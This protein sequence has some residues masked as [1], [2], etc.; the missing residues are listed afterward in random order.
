[1]NELP[2]ELVNRAINRWPDFV[3]VHRPP[4][5]D[6]V[7]PRH[8]G[9]G[10]VG[11]TWTADGKPHQIAAEYWQ[12]RP[13][14]LPRAWTAFAEQL[15]SLLDGRETPAVW[16]PR[17]VAA[18]GTRRPHEQAD[19]RCGGCV[20]F[21]SQA[22]IRDMARRSEEEGI[23]TYSS[24]GSLYVP[25]SRS[26]GFTI[27]VLPELWGRPWDAKAMNLI[28]TLRPSYVRV[29]DADGE[30]KTDSRVWRVTVFVTALGVIKSIQQEVTCG[31]RGGFENGHA[32][33]QWHARLLRSADGPPLG[34]DVRRAEYLIRVIYSRNPCGCCWHV[35][36][37]DGNWEDH[38]V[39][40]CAGRATTRE[41]GGSPCETPD[42]CRELGPILRAMP[43]ERRRQLRVPDWQ[44]RARLEVGVDT[45]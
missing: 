17:E 2:K 36:V 16:L 34:R 27:P 8:L 31:L 12:Q 1:M 42:A 5:D 41:E 37:D 30:L 7:S 33:S 22:R 44:E 40:F 39:E 26:S 6:P 13:E 21:D 29:A 11:A 28:D 18:E 10:L 35:V 9:R 20:A 19:C 24:T 32:V 3:V 14:T 15:E 38:A 45:P 23:P 4:E 43:E 25:P